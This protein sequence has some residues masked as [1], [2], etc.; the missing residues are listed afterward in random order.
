VQLD[1][2]FITLRISHSVTYAHFL[3]HVK[4]AF[5]CN[6][7][8]LLRV[9]YVTADGWNIICSDENLATA[10]QDSICSF[11]I[12]SGPFSQ[13]AINASPV[14]STVAPHL[15]YRSLLSCLRLSKIKLGI[16]NQ[17][18]LGHKKTCCQETGPGG[19]HC[20]LLTR[21]QLNIC[22]VLHLTAVNGIE[23]KS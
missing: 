3:I 6:P 22:T 20:G 4:R 23:R 18:T 8:A 15:L 7:D 17:G 9:G 5:Q 10:L 14:G 16:Q 21:H 11:Q 2:E 19:G 13:A 12:L 1:E